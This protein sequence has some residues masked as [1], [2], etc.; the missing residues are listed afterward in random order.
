MSKFNHNFVPSE[1]GDCYRIYESGDNKARIDFVSESC[2][3]VAIYKTESEMLPTFCVNPDNRFLIKGRSRLDISGFSLCSPKT[4][5][6]ENGERFTLPCGVELEV[7]FHNF[8]LTY[9]R[10]GKNLFSDRKPLSYN[11]AGE[12]GRESFHYI[13]REA[14]EKVFGLGDKTGELNKAGKAYRIETT[15]CMGYDAAESDP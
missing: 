5:R 11:F 8:I 15:D 2:V 14:G 13:T 6:S 4:E 1:K 12:F 3:R 9:S 7:N 10:D